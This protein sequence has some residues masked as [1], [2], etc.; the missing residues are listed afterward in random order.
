MK[1]KS[2]KKERKAEDKSL[3]KY[4]CQYCGKLCK[5]ESTLLL[6]CLSEHR[7]NL[8]DIAN[9]LANKITK[10]VKINQSSENM[11]ED[12]LAGDEKSLEQNLKTDEELGK[13]TANVKIKL[14]EAKEGGDEMAEVGQGNVHPAQ[15]DALKTEL[16][17]TIKELKFDLERT[18][19][20]LKSLKEE[21]L[22]KE[23]EERVNSLVN[24]LKDS[25]T[26]QLTEVNKLTTELSEQF[27]SLQQ[28][29]DADL[30]QK[31][32]VSKKEAEEA[33]KEA[34]QVK[35][36]LE[37]LPS[38]EKI[39]ELVD[40]CILDPNS[41]ACKRLDA[42]EK[43]TRQESD[44]EKSVHS[45]AAE[46]LACPTCGPAVTK[47][48][49]AALSKAGK[50]GIANEVIKAMSEAGYE[51]GITPKEE[52]PSQAE[53]SGNPGTKEKPSEEQRF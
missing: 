47:R 37:Q 24:P 2:E 11:K 14:N 42:L 6:H 8:P 17:S 48:I 33:K 27:K 44:L 39:K 26:G 53:S 12:K 4:V 19:E 34:E 40:A 21:K 20:A 35:Q 38:E 52:K 23:V 49:M 28:A 7:E 18:N 45:T 36:K 16:N 3:Y 13:V 25:I 51:T 1:Q 41:A 43:A 31:L 46:L 22:P 29:L 9:E 32:E 50:D 10:P 30:K 5:N 15:L